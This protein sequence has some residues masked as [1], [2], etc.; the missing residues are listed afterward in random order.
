MFE[1][2]CHVL[3]FFL[4]SLPQKDYSAAA[5]RVQR[6]EQ[7]AGRDAGLRMNIESNTQCLLSAFVNKLLPMHTWW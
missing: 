1:E 6:L 4:L 3:F 2:K 5:V 7:E